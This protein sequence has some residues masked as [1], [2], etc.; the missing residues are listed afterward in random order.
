VLAA[1]I[2]MK[3]RYL[4]HKDWGLFICSIKVIAGGTRYEKNDFAITDYDYGDVIRACVSSFRH[5]EK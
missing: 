5:I 1:L 3:M 2:L 4:F